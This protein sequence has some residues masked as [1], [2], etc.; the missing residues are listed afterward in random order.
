MKLNRRD[1]LKAAAAATAAPMINLG[2]FQ[3]FAEANDRY[4]T[5][6]IDLVQRTTTLDMLNPFSLY[7]TLAPLMIKPG[8][9]PARTWFNDPATFTQKDMVPFRESGINVYHI[10]VGTGGP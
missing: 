9:T 10:A 2:S 7:A 1:M 5:R 8:E 4:S 3:L 6:A